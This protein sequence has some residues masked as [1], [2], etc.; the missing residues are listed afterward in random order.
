MPSAAELTTLVTAVTEA[1]LGDTLNTTQD[2]TVFAPT[3]DAFAAMD[4]ETL[5]AALAGRSG[6]FR[7]GQ[8]HEVTLAIAQG[9]LGRLPRNLVVQLVARHA[10]ALER[11]LGADNGQARQGQGEHQHDQHGHAALTLR[12]SAGGCARRMRKLQVHHVP[13]TPRWTGGS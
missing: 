3:D 12:P 5:N 11:Q 9:R 6:L 10:L 8:Q 4:Q 2:I 1:G 7:A 13:I